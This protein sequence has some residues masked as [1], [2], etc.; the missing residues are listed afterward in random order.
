MDAIEQLVWDSD[1]AAAVLGRGE[2]HTLVPFDGAG[3]P[4]AVTKNGHRRG[5]QFC[6]VLALVGGRA[7]AK[8]EPDPESLAVMVLAAIA[9]NKANG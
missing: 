2:E 7:A 1:E 4:E 6:G 8:C 5:F 9:F 3:I